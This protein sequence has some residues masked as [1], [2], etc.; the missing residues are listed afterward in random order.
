M[1]GWVSLCSCGVP[2]VFMWRSRGVPVSTQ[3]AAGGLISHCSGTRRPRATC[4]FARTVLGPRWC[5]TADRR[6]TAPESARRSRKTSTAGESLLL[7]LYTKPST[8]FFSSF[9]IPSSMDAIF[10]YFCSLSFGHLSTISRVFLQG[11]QLSKAQQEM[12]LASL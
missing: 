7:S 9:F 8:F 11:F 10:T 5:G 3:V 2:S 4:W 12:P 6:N 1:W